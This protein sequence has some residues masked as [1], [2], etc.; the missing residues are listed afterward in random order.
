MKQYVI[1]CLPLPPDIPWPSIKGNQCVVFIIL[2]RFLEIGDSVTL[3]R[4]GN[5]DAQRACGENIHT[6]M[7]CVA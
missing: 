5:R 4:V 6:G 3:V 7:K 2:G 1:K